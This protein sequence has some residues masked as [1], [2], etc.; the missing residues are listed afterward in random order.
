M[1]SFFEVNWKA[2]GLFKGLLK[3]IWGGD[4]PPFDGLL[5]MTG[6]IVLQLSQMLNRLLKTRHW[7]TS[8]AA[9]LSGGLS[10]SAVSLGPELTKSLVAVMQSNEV[11]TW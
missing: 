7:A 1:L 4:G 3:L 8:K 2:F 9:W 10:F 5:H 11:D 6:D